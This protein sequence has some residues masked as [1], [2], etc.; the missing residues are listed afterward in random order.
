MKNQTI[1]EDRKVEVKFNSQPTHRHQ[2]ITMEEIANRLLL[3][4]LTR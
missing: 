1:S 4:K 3:R 2:V